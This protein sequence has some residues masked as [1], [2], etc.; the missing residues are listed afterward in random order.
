MVKELFHVFEGLEIRPESQGYFKDAMVSSVVMHKEQGIVRVH[1]ILNTLIP[2]QCIADLEEGIFRHLGYPEGIQIHVLEAYELSYEL[3]LKELYKAYEG[4]LM[5]TLKKINPVGAAIIRDAQVDIGEQDLVYQVDKTRFQYLKT[6]DFDQEIIYV[7]KQKFNKVIDVEI[8]EDDV[9]SH[10]YQEFIRHRDMEQKNLLKKRDR[11]LQIEEKVVIQEDDITKET[12]ENLILGKKPI[13]GEILKLKNFDEDTTYANIDV[14]VIGKPD[15]RELRGGKMI[16]KIDVTDF[17]DSIT[18]KAFVEKDDFPHVEAKVKKGSTLRIRGLYK[19]DDYD[20]GRVFFVNTIEA[21]N[22]NLKIQRKDTAK[23]KRVE[24]HLHTQMSD[25]D[26][27]MSVKD[28]IQQAIAW[29]HKAIAITDHGVVQGYTDAFHCL[30]D[31]NIKVLYGVEAYIVDDQKP[32]GYFLDERTFEDT[33]I[34]FDIETTGLRAHK[35]KFTEIGAVKIKGGKVVDRFSEFVQPGV[36]I[37]LHI[38][39]LTHIQMKLLKMHH[40]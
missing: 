14:Q 27:V 31:D 17:T 3:G 35:D 29:G 34:V 4:S 11:H 22:I 15:V 21:I 24:L 19:Y 7:F 18:A 13:V 36:S 37:P 16:V 5:Y 23:E 6:L 10:I 25:M 40:R 2:P 30:H 38:Q 28:G 9:K 8:L 39:E 32:I 1:I 26:G 20:R 33:F 12:Y